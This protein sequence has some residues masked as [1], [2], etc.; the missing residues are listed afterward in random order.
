MRV[1]LLQTSP[2]RPDMPALG[3][4][5]IQAALREAGVPT[6][7]R[8]LNFVLYEQVNPTRRPWW[9]PSHHYV[10]HGSP[11][12]DEWLSEIEPFVDRWVSASL[13]SP[14]PVLVGITML[15]TQKRFGLWLAERVKHL[16]PDAQVVVGGPQCF[17]Q[18]EP[19]EICAHPAV[20]HV[21]VGEGEYA[22]VDLVRWLG[23]GAE[24]P[25]PAG[26]MSKREGV[27]LSGE[28]RPLDKDI[29][30]LPLP[31]YTGLP[32]R[33]YTDAGRLPLFTSRGCVRKCVFCIEQRIWERFRYRS[34][35]NVFAEIER[36]VRL[37]GAERFE[38]NDSLFNGHMRILEEL[39]DLILA[40]GLRLS[41][42]G[43]G[44][45]RAEMSPRV[46]AKLKAAGCG[47]VTYGFESAS[48]RVLDAMKKNVDMTVAARV[49]RDT[50]EAGIGQKLNL[51]FGFPGETEA[52][53]QATLDFLE[54]NARFIDEVNPS[55]AFTAIIPGT[56]LYE[57]AAEFGVT[58]L[59]NSWF[60]EADDGANNFAV[61]LDRFERLCRHVKRLGIASTYRH[62]RV[63]NRH[64]AL[65][66]WALYK[67]RFDDAE[68]HYRAHAA[69]MGL[70]PEQVPNWSQALRAAH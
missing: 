47:F 17:V 26:V 69:E 13:A 23:A 40:S 2:W 45:I 50:H 22:I 70:R 32:L 15:A 62:E 51:M 18:Y 6:V 39:C 46:L 58:T 1:V 49:I 27:V 55:D 56:E 53:F 35:A 66:D 7:L 24:G 38:I 44:V 29:D 42:G 65:G 20:D 28:P 30:Q 54:Q 33:T 67:E 59:H 36:G 57:R 48:Q 21:V 4:P 14:G 12:L 37:W 60:W 5:Y 68:R 3:L 41:W 43:Q 25:P 31:D 16:R 64:Q 9:E 8:D 11:Q 19:A 34:A 10:W 61:R 52:E 63:V